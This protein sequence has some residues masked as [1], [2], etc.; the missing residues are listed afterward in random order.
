MDANPSDDPSALSQLRPWS[1]TQRG[2]E[3]SQLL[4]DLLDLLQ[5]GECLLLRNSI[6]KERLTTIEHQLCAWTHEV[7]LVV[8]VTPGTH[9]TDQTLSLR[10]C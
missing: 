5:A 7:T 8:T 10:I 1:L 9:F 4:L 2:I 3:L 6:Y